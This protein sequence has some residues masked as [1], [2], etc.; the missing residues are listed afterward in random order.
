MEYHQDRFEDLSLMV[1]KN[2][3][4]IAILP[5]NVDNGTIYSHQGLSYGGLV[6]SEKT[7][8]EDVL[9]SF[10]AILR[11][12]QKNEIETFQLKVIPSIY[13]SFPSDEINH[14]LFKTN[15]QLIRREM[16]WVI[17]LLH[18]TEI[19]SNN[20]KRGLKRAENK[21]LIIKEEESFDLFWSEILIPNLQQRHGVSPVHTLEEITLL[22]SRF[23]KN[24]RQFNVYYNETIV[25]GTTIFETDRVAHAQY[26]S[27][28]EFKQEL[29][30]LDFLFHQLINN[31]FKDKTYFD[32]GISS[33]D[34]G[35]KLNA[36]LLSWKE[37]F[38]A[39]SITYD[40]Y[41]VA[42]HNVDLLNNLMI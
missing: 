23:P 15:A 11:Y 40:F 2:N 35:Q 3:K 29:G 4:I 14:L 5:A 12:L 6:V 1:L 9:N 41:K 33:E 37:S 26:I 25:G 32:F 39:R 16:L 7:K 8:F 27:A 31:T 24:I 36:G 10:K 17:D 18:R 13:N 20:R 42:T 21:N 19:I 38:G 22:K 34:R 30:T 28:N